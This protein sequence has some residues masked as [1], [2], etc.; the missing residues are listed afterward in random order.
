MACSAGFGLCL[1]ADYSRSPIKSRSRGGCDLLLGQSNKV[2]NRQT[3]L[4][5]PKRCG[6]WTRTGDFNH[7]E[8]GFD[9]LAPQA[10]VAVQKSLSA[11]NTCQPARTSAVASETRS[12]CNAATRK[13]WP[14]KACAIDVVRSTTTSRLRRLCR[15]HSA[16]GG[17]RI[18]KL[19]PQAGTGAMCAGD[20]TDYRPS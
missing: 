9:S 16:A 20:V 19:R 13:N 10:S 18:L 8:I 5:A 15:M 14:C 12:C 7:T 4:Q 2:V 11:E 17:G 3:P 1:T 6:G